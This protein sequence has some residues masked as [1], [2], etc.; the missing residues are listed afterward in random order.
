MHPPINIGAGGISSISLTSENKLIV[1]GDITTDTLR[2]AF[3]ALLDSTGILDTGFGQNGMVIFDIGDDQDDFSTVLVK[4]DGNILLAG[5]TYDSN[6]PSIDFL[7]VQ[8]LPDGTPDP[9]FGTTGIATADFSEGFESIL[10]LA[11][12]AD[13]KIVAA[14]GSYYNDYNMEVV[15]FDPDGTIDQS[16]GNNGLF[17]FGLS[18]REEI[19]YSIAVQSDQKIVFCGTSFKNGSTSGEAT[20]FRLQVDGTFDTTFGTNGQVFT[21]LGM[22]EF[23]RNL[24]LQP[25]GKIV[26]GAESS[27][28]NNPEAGWLWVM[29]YN[30]DGSLDPTF[31]NDGKAQSFVYE[32]SPEC[33]AL[34]L[35]PDGKII[36]TGTVG[37][38]I[39]LLRYLNDTALPALE[40][41]VT[42]L[43]LH[44]F[45]NLVT[46]DATLT[47][48]L[49]A[50]HEVR[51]DLYDTQGQFI[52][53]CITPVLLQAGTYSQAIHLGKNVP[54]G[55]YFLV[56]N[57]ENE[58]QVLKLTKL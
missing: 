25:D 42:D 53:S 34:L 28:P 51:C 48:V 22:L 52:Q 58:R 57:I 50:T 8:I 21:E 47:W 44:C 33:I 3:V 29:R 17:K 27:D 2:A 36:Q 39:I 19:A 4:P 7:I 5:Y 11:L 26:V 40:T 32:S 43:Q 6:T 13:G 24:L 31:G 20:L 16:F 14:C 55:T 54:S 18:N 23:A 30:S 1:A 10:S 49:N 15:R 45:P 12:Q 56:F 46:E 41:P 38:S 9:A 37:S 35:Q